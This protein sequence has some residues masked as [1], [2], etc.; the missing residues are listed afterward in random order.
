[1]PFKVQVHT[2]VSETGNVVA[3]CPTR[4]VNL[5]KQVGMIKTVVYSSGN[6]PEST[7][8]IPNLTWSLTPSDRS[9]YIKPVQTFRE[10]LTKLRLL[11]SRT[12]QTSGIF[13]HIFAALFLP[14]WFG[15]GSSTICHE[16]CE[17]SSV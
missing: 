11:I 12:G 9:I 6:V 17:G 16:R 3:S 5:L 13:I 10:M 2:I 15:A 7:F 8:A 1:M 4:D 14:T